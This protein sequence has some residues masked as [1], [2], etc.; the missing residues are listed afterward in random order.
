VTG[1]AELQRNVPK[2]LPS[3]EWLIVLALQFCAEFFLREGE[4]KNYLASNDN[5]DH[6]NE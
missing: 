4:K 5:V 2:A 3:I 1:M 6:A